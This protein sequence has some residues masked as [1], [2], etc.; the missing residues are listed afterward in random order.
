MSQFLLGDAGPR[1]GSSCIGWFLSKGITEWD[2]EWIQMVLCSW[3]FPIPPPSPEKIELSSASPTRE[4]PSCPL[5]SL[6]LMRVQRKKLVEDES[7]GS[8]STK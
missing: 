1:L 5:R 7:V 6:D 3:P 8:E 2:R 4:V